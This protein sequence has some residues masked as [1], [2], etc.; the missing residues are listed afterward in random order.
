MADLVCAP[1]HSLVHQSLHATEA[2]TGTNGDGFGLGW[3]GERPEPGLYRDIRPAWSDENLKSLSRPGALA[4]VL[5]PCARLDRHGLDAGELPPLRRT[6][7]TCSCITARSAAT[8]ASG[9]AS[10]T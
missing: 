7:G 3:Y 1:A 6:G 5:R 9:G 8:T 10:R 4:P 2:K